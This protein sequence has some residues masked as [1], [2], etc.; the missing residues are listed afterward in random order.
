[1]TWSDQALHQASQE[2]REPKLGHSTFDQHM[3]YDT[4]L[5]ACDVRCGLM[6]SMLVRCTYSANAAAFDEVSVAANTVPAISAGRRC[7]GSSLPAH[8]LQA[9][10]AGIC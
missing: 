8:H 9:V 7:L 6:L 1:M 5:L 4:V 10:Y 2:F 3:S